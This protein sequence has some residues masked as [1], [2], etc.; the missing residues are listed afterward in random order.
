MFYLFVG[1]SPI[2]FSALLRFGIFPAF[3]NIISGELMFQ[4]LCI[5]LSIP[6]H[7]PK[8]F[9]RVIST[10]R[11]VTAG[12]NNADAVASHNLQTG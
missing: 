2:S 10:S 4:V 6:H 9:G 7:C 8:F 1:I 3:S 12:G 5:V 11:E